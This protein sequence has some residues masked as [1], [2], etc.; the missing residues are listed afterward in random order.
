MHESLDIPKRVATPIRCAWCGLVKAGE[1]WRNERRNILKMH[2]SHGICSR[3]ALEHFRKFLQ[4]DS[5][6]P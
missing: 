5:S 3:C 1:T 2:Y 6:R 4:P